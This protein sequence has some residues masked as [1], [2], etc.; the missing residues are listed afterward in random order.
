MQHAEVRRLSDADLDAV[1]VHP[2][3][4]AAV[5][6][7]AVWCMPCRMMEPVVRRLAS[8]F[9]GRVLV[10]QINTDEHQ[11]AAERMGISAVPT[12]LLFQHGAV[13]GRFLGVTA[14]DKIASA[15]ERLMQ[16][17]NF[18]STLDSKLDRN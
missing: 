7:W 16:D 15:L 13:V 4:L 11:A 18:D 12:I 8:S 3:V 14:F 2:G 5:E 1:V 10:G 9:E 6:F 17:T